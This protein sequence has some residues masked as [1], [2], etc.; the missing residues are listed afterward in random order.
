VGEDRLRSRGRLGALALAAAAVAA[1]AAGCGGGAGA[2]KAGKTTQPIVLHMANGYADLSYEPA[3]AYFVNRV[4]QVSRGSL[5]IDVESD[6]GVREG[7]PRPG[8]E[9][10][11][12]RDVADGKADLGWVG[13]RT[14]DTLGVNSFQALTAPMLIDGYRLEGAVMASAIPHRMLASLARLHLA[15]LAVLADGLR[16]P[17]GVKRPLVS[18]TDWH[19]ITFAVIRSRAEADAI[20]ALGAAPTDIWSAQ[21]NDALAAGKVDGF[22]KNLLV[23]QVN[24]TQEVAPYVTANVNLW[25]Q[26]VAL[27]ANPRRLA[28]L[29][30]DERAWIRQAAADAAAHSTGLVDVDARSALEACKAGARFASAPETALVALRQ[31]FA[32]LYRSLERDPQTKMFIL[33]IE[34]LKRSTPAGPVLAIPAWC[35]TNARARLAPAAPAAGGNAAVLNGVYRI[36]WTAKELLHDGANWR[37]VHTNCGQRCVMTMRLQDGRYSFCKGSSRGCAGVYTVLGDNIDL[38]GYFRARWS[39]RNGELSFTDIVAPD[40]GDN[41]FFGTKPWRKIG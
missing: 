29:S 26:T 13:T 19:G 25:P 22:E 24:G 40:G 18:L 14:F 21:L 9:Q 38:R 16:K 11:V 3:I 12:V 1:V 7:T 15:G 10:R 28:G 23:Y 5:R 34:Q 39:L 27:I 2:T 33:R 8:F 17:I 36:G 41:V 35:R 4:R 37:Y 20:R 32:P 6:W 31:A 30:A